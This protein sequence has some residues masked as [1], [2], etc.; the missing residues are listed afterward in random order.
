MSES[1]SYTE[2][3][4]N[5]LYGDFKFKPYYHVG[6][7]LDAFLSYVCHILRTIYDLAATLLRLTWILL[8]VPN[9]FEWLGLPLQ[10]LELLDD[11]TAT[12]VSAFTVAIY[13]AIFILRSL[14]SVFSGYEKIVDDMLK[15]DMEESGIY[16][17]EESDLNLAWTIWPSKPNQTH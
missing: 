11:I 4:I 14:S 7:H 1:V 17:E 16:K 10:A 6:F 13:P 3:A 15:V 5:A 12:L 2:V 9:P 8:C